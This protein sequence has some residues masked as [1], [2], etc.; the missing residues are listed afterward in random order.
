MTASLSSRDGAKPLATLSR[1]LFADSDAANLRDTTR[2]LTR[3][4]YQVDTARDGAMAAEFFLQG[5]YNAILCDAQ[6]PGMPALELLRA[7]RR[8]DLDVPIIFFD[9]TKQA[10][11]ALIAHDRGGLRCLIKPVS[12]ALLGEVVAQAILLHRMAQAK[13]EALLAL[14]E[15]D[16]QSD[17]EA[18]ADARY[19]RALGTLWIAWQPI[20]DWQERS[21]AAYEALMRSDEA[22]L[23]HPGAIIDAAERLGRLGELGRMVRSQVAKRI[24][25]APPN[26]DI[27]VNLHTFDLLDDDLFDP[28]APLSCYA[29]RVV[30]EITERIALDEVHDVPMRV[31][32]LRRL[33]F[34]IAVDDLGAGYAGLASFAQL[35]PEVVKLDMSLIRGLHRTPTKRKVIQ[36]LVNLCQE[37][38][39]KVVAEGIE[40]AQERECLMTLGCTVMQGYLFAVPDRNF[41]QETVVLQN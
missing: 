29:R 40:T 27:Y 38:R 37:L 6:L 30:L 18:D 10:A 28:N 32:A 25:E 7:V 34:R 14:G 8:F 41:P 4:G 19:S 21:V 15:Q 39:I 16:K 31:A 23:P 36:T 24:C 2:F 3:T 22:T 17:P 1:L 35:E 13:R 33:G 11:E 9:T 20:V 5:E 12:P 26:V